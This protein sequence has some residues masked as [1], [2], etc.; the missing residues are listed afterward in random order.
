MSRTLSITSAA[1]L[2]LHGAA[3]AQTPKPVPPAPQPIL[4]IR[5]FGPAAWRSRLG[6]TN[7][8]TMLA[9]AQAEAIWRSYVDAAAA[10]FRG[11]RCDEVAFAREWA[12]ALDYAGAIAIVV[13]L[14]QAEDALHSARW[15]MAIV[16]EPDG[17]TDL[18]ALA[19]QS[20]AWLGDILGV[21][22]G[23]HWRDLTLVPPQ[24][25]DGRIVAVLACPE[26]VDAA[27]ARA[28]ALRPPTLAAPSV[29]NVEI[30]PDAAL[31]LARDRPE[32]RDW[33]RALI[34]DA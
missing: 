19:A 6:P 14:E 27:I 23:R 3:W 18:G 25:R 15:S 16:A 12:R 22:Q 21:E 10:S 26:D 34:G 31:G 4:C 1:I 11:A 29:L 7:L 8:G 20:A 13:W 28:V 24:V 32:D 9:S 2:A 30:D 17:Q 5:T 33:W